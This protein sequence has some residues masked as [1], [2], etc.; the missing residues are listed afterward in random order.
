MD[1]E[2][3]QNYILKEEKTFLS[4]IKETPEHYNNYVRLCA[5]EYLDANAAKL[6]Y[7]YLLQFNIK[8]TYQTF[9]YLIGACVQNK[10]PK[11]V[12]EYLEEVVFHYPQF[13][14]KFIH[15]LCFA[16]EK[17]GKPDA[18]QRADVF[19]PLLKKTHVTK[20]EF[21]KTLAAYIDQFETVKPDLEDEQTAKKK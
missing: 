20:A 14:S 1:K 4:K 5:T 12:I 6:G 3:R 8:L 21:K 15:A 11:R 9:A 17:E 16:F 13:H 19:R 18:K 10:H 2:T 7:Q